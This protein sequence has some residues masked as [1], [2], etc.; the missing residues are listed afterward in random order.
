MDRDKISHEI[1]NL[2]ERLR[3]MHD[4]AKNKNYSVVKKEELVCDLSETLKEIENH[5]QSLIQ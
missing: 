1:L 5:F 3:V 4:L 2:L